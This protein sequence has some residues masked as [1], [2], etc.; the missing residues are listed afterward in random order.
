MNGTQAQT[1]YSGLANQ[2]AIGPRIN[3]LNELEIQ[4]VFSARAKEDCGVQPVFQV[5]QRAKYQRPVP[6]EVKPRVVALGF[7]QH[8]FPQRDKPATLAILDENLLVAP[9][10]GFGFDAANFSEGRRQPLWS[11]RLQ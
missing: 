3:R 2:P 8:D 6:A 7:Q 9:N 1:V 4:N 10:G 5:I 11:D